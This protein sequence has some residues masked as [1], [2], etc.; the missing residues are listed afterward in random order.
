MDPAGALRRPPSSAR[1][2]AS[3]ASSAWRCSMAT[4]RRRT[5]EATFAD[6]SVALAWGA[7]TELGVSGWTSTH[8]DWAIDPEPLILFTA[9]LGDADPRL[10]D[11]ATDW[12]VQNWRHI[13]KARLKNLLR[14]GPD[15]I[16]A[17]FGE[18]AATVGAHAG[19]SWPGATQPRR[20]TVTGRSTV[21]HLGRPSL[22][23]LR[24]RA[25]FG[26]SARAEILRCFL[27]LGGGAVS[28][29]AL[30][31]ATGYTKR[32]V[33][34]ECETLQHAGVLSVRAQGNRFYYSLARRVE[35]SAFA[36][37]MPAILTDW[38]AILNVS[39][40]L[41]ALERRSMEAGLPTLPVHARQTL[42]RIG[43]DLHELDIER[44]PEN[45][46]AADLWPALRRLGDV[47]LGAWATGQWP[48]QDRAEAAHRRRPSS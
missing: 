6:Q 21:P 23:W 9:W 24:L 5:A 12:C 15:D 40:E 27:A 3:S 37:E 35:L 32:N 33:A 14:N 10:R 26:V 4:S 39:R 44:P 42:K 2:N 13:S 31:A 41:V 17:A 16:A 7:W 28:V 46:E 11:E 1:G 36:G 45:I 22:V 38:T 43:D 47:H 29:A 18:L 25:M 8:A 30:A 19:I 20:Y 48:S 34:E